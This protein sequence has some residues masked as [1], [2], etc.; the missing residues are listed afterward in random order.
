[1][2]ILTTFFACNKDEEQEPTSTS[3]ILYT[4]PEETETH[5]GT[6]LQWPHH[7]QYGVSYRNSLD[8]TWVSMTKELVTSE[9]VHI[10]A[11]SQ[12]EKDR[13]IAL[14]NTA[15]V[16]LTNVD[17]KIYQTSHTLSF[18]YYKFQINSF[19]ENVVFPRFLFSF[20]NVIV[21]HGK[22]KGRLEIFKHFKSGKMLR[23]IQ[24]YACQKIMIVCFIF[25]R[26]SY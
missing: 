17:F 6:W 26:V 4:M 12:T 14:L 9:K 19:K 25:Y 23:V 21:L 24:L 15:S 1:M 22:C 8:Q 2:T 11:Y 5:E 13:I 16:P 20:F 3:E 10:I 18:F 7:Y